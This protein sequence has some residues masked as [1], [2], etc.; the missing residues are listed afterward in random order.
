MQFLTDF[1]EFRLLKKALILQWISLILYECNC[2]AG[3][4]G[5]SAAGGPGRPCASSVLR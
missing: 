4:A 2:F 3:A 5:D 1:I